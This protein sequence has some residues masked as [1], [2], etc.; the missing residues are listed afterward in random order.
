MP[1]CIKVWALIQRIYTC[2][3]WHRV[4]NGPTFLHRRIG[5]THRSFIFLKFWRHS[6]FFGTYIKDVSPGH[7]NSFVCMYTY[8]LRGSAGSQAHVC[9]PWSHLVREKSDLFT[10][11]CSASCTSLTTRWHKKDRSENEISSSEFE[12]KEPWGKG[13]ILPS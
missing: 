11:Q 12:S 9:Y 13:G 1:H 2:L 10:C 3:T 4:F 6:L 7:K 5:I 8:F